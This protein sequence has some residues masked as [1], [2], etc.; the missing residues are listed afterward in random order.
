M[1][2]KVLE[3]FA[4]FPVVAVLGARQ[5]GKTTLV[6]KLGIP[7]L[8]TFTLDST[9]D[10]GGARADPDFFLQQQPRPLFLDEVQYAPELLG[11]LKRE[12]D[13]RQTPGQFLLSGSQNLAVLRSVS[14]SLAGRVS[15]VE[16]W[17]LSLAESGGDPARTGWLERAVRGEAF[18][19]QQTAAVGPPALFPLLW[20]GGLPGLLTLPDHLCPT[21]FSSYRQT[22]IE[23]DVRTAAGVSSLQ[24]FGRFIGLLAALTASEVNHN[25]LGRELGVDRKTALAWT[26]IASATYQWHEV[27]AYSRNAIKRLAGKPKGFFSDTGLACHFQG[28][29]SAE[30]LLHHPGA[31]RLFETWVF[32]EVKK[33][34]AIWNAGPNI[35]HYRTLAGAEVDLLLEMDGVLHPIEVKMTANPSRRDLRGIDSFRDTFPKARLGT[36]LLVCAIPAATRLR[37][38]LWAVPWWEL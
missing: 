34:T 27:P 30:Q 23:R 36:G 31:G 32:G 10:L 7:G 11:S 35:F 20:R 21:Y 5:V 17:P 4:H 1:E 19:E 25:E 29:T 12:V 28:L 24:H 38:D 22:Y 13:R 16:L 2:Q 37:P 3:L 8:K 14:E 26:G 18:P 15:I 6:E 33:R 9:I